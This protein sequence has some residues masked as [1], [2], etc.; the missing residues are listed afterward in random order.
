M[1]PP[2][3]MH[4]DISHRLVFGK[5]LFSHKARSHDPFLRIR[6]LLVPKSD[7]VNTFKMT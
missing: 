5:N 3:V 6:F 7:R 1:D 2:N 4:R